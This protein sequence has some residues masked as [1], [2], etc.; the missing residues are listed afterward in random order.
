MK[1]TGKLALAGIGLAGVV[2]VGAL[3]AAALPAQA[4]STTS[5]ADTS[6]TAPDPSQGG[7]SANGITETILTGEEAAKVQ[8]AV[9]AAYPDATIER[10]ET[11]AEGAAFEAHIVQADGTESTVK[12]DASYAITGTEAGHGGGPGGGPGRDHDGGPGRDHDGDDT[13]SDTGSSTD[14]S[15]TS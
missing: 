7:H 11:D 6:T 15:T 3:T 10:L 4:E 1:K 12:L 13:D 2:A 9:E 8:A 14:G 5:P